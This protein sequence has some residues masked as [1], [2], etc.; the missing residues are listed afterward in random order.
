MSRVR[1]NPR[2]AFQ[3]LDGSAFLVQP[4]DHTMHRLDEVGTFIWEALAEPK[5]PQEAAEAVAAAF[6]V[7][8]PIAERDT[9]EFLG[10][11]E[12]RGLVIID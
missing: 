10:E 4:R 2:V 12:R 9:R 11:L 8:P 5:S 3:I 1:Q 7:E 6:E